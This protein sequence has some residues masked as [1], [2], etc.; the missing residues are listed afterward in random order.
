LFVEIAAP[1]EGAEGD[2]SAS[3][4]LAR[5]SAHETLSAEFHRQHV[6]S[7]GSS[8]RAVSAESVHD[9]ERFHVSL[10]G[11]GPVNAEL[12]SS[13][14]SMGKHLLLSIFVDPPWLRA[15]EY[16]MFVAALAGIALAGSRRVPYSWFAPLLGSLAVCGHY[17]PLHL[18]KSAAGASILGA[19]IVSGAV[20]GLGALLIEFALRRVWPGSRGAADARA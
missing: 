20:G 18:G 10:P 14:G 19:F 7:R 12:T 15:L 1:S 2:G 17:L 5:G 8:R 13:G 3:V 16:V 4:T 9:S 11:Q 6:A